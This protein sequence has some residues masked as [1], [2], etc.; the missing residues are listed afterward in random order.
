MIMMRDDLNGRL[1]ALDTLLLRSRLS[2]RSKSDLP[3]GQDF[4]R[5]MTAALP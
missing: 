4:G 1:L 5:Q 2:E 3:L